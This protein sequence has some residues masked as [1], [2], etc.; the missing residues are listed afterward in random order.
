MVRFGQPAEFLH[1]IVSLQRIRA[2]RDLGNAKKGDL[3][4]FIEHEGNLS[5]EVIVG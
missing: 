3:G 2:L 5:H 4:G 1:R